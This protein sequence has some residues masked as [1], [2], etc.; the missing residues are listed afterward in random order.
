[1]INKK[2][3]LR[4]NLYQNLKLFSGKKVCAMVKS[5][6]YGHGIEAIVKLLSDKVDYFGVANETEGRL[7]RKITDKPILVVGKATNL[8]I[9]KQNNLEIMVD[10]KIM[11]EKAAKLGL[12]IHLKINCGMNRFGVSSIFSARVIN[13]ML[14][15]NKI[16]LK[17]IFCHFS[18]TSNAKLTKQ[19]YD[20]FLKIRN[21][22]TQNVT[23]CFGG[24][25]ITKYPFVYDMIRVGIGLYG[26]EMK[27]LQPVM[28][29]KSK[30]IKVFY[31]YKGEYIGYGKKYKIKRNGFF[32]IVP[33]GYGDGLFRNLSGKFSVQ[34]GEKT[35][36]SV[37]NICMD[38][39]FIKVDG[40]VKSGDEVVVLKN[41]QDF[42]KKLNTI[43]YE[44]LTNF[45]KIRADTIVE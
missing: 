16:V 3:I 29:I 35:Y 2:V 18:D 6:A 14:K 38:M 39:F 42:A 8:M 26:Y 40:S 7:V 5:D 1:M 28:K 9:C 11:I 17:S 34:I 21:C 12:G 15:E 24:S 13:K 33:V 20:R 22:I 4:E 23:I 32:A 31:A 36:K 45:S 44:V 27:N 30:V 41:A 10:D 25:N 37:G 19:Q 43:S